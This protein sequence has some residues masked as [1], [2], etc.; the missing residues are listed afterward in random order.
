MALA[1]CGI[2]YLDRAE[3]FSRNAIKHV[4]YLH[5]HMHIAAKPTIVLAFGD[6]VTTDQGH[7]FT[8]LFKKDKPFTLTLRP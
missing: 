5:E 2:L 7:F 1:A 4:A 3:Q 8:T 6:S